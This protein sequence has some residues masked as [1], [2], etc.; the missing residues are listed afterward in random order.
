T[1]LLSTVAFKFGEQWEDNSLRQSTL[2]AP[3]VQG[4]LAKMACQ[5]V[6][7]AIVEVTSHG[8]ALD[9]VRQCLFDQA[10]VT[11]ITSEHLEFHGTRERY[12]AAKALL[13]E[14]VHDG[15]DRPGPHFAAINCDDPGSAGLIGG[16]PV[17]VVTFGLS[18]GARVR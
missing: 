5:G 16:S 14:A 8:L 9:R 7:E 11:N 13:L 4:A 17:E 15:S 6:G 2:E 1:G 3:E 12:I 10:L 18:D